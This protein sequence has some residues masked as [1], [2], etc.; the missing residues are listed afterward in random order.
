AI[1]LGKTKDNSPSTLS[2]TDIFPEPQVFTALKADGLVRTAL[3]AKGVPVPSS[4]PDLLKA[5]EFEA[6]QVGECSYTFGDDLLGS[7]A[8]YSVK[9]HN[10]A[11]RISLSHSAEVCRGQI[12]Q[13]GL[14]LPVPE[15]LKIQLNQAR[16]R[17]AGFL[18]ED[19]ERISHGA[20]TVYKLSQRAS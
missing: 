13:I 1:D 12:T 18:M 2:L 5:L 15:S 17:R 3:A 9:D 8:F 10:V 7:F 16:Q 4:L 19:A 11:V 14:Q 20:T 6:V